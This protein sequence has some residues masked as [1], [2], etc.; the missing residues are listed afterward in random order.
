MVTLSEKD[1]SLEKVFQ[2]IQRQTG[3]EFVYNR[4]WVQEF[5]K[6]TVD[7]KNASL[8]QVLDLCFKDQPF[9]YEIVNKIVSVSERK[10]QARV[11]DTARRPE[12]PID[13]H[14]RVTDSAGTPLQGAIIQVAGTKKGTTTDDNGD[15]EMKVVNK[16]AT[17]VVSFVGYGT[18]KIPIGGRMDLA[19]ALHITNF[20]LGQAVVSVSNGY[21]QIPK[22]RATGS[23]AFEDNELFNRRASSDMLSCY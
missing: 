6:V 19:I 12:P 4:R 5:K 22:E 20:E 23:F 16:E 9:T 7:V 21:Q 1:A 3:Y 10:G 13:I 15:F 2:D 18:R 11:R 17:L 14:G 8:N